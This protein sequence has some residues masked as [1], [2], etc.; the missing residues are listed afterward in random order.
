MKRLMMI[1]PLWNAD[2]GGGGAAPAAAAPAAAA[3]A[4]TSA[5]PADGAAA[6]EPAGAPVPAAAAAAADYWPETLDKSFKGADAKSTL[7]NLATRLADNDKA[8]KGYR[9]AD[10]RRDVVKTVEEMVDFSKAPDFK[11]EERNKPYFDALATDPLFK[12]VADTAIKDGV[13]R[14]ALGN[15]YQNFLNAASEA[16]LLEPAIDPKAERAA[17]LPDTA[18]A[19]DPAGQDAAIDKRMQENYDWLALAAQNMKLPAE[20]GKYA[21]LM[22]G[23][24]AKGHQFFEWVRQTVQGGQGTG[25]PGA[26]GSPGGGS[27]TRESLRAEMAAL[28]KNRDAPDYGKKSKELDERYKRMFPG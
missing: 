9:D 22:L 27:D 2:G 19:L 28:E 25:G 26:H 14:R 11:V 10:A 3:G 24:S 16:G 7:D 18:K 20:A 4:G 1:S 12:A 8:L 23:D 21:E 17:L 6:A 15:L 5:V 13:G